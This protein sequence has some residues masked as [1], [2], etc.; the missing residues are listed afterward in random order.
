MPGSNS[1]PNV[2]EGYEI[3]SEL[4]GRPAI[5]LYTYFN[6]HAGT[7]QMGSASVGDR[8]NRRFSIIIAE[9]NRAFW[10]AEKKIAEMG[11]APPNPTWGPFFS[12]IFYY[13]PSHIHL[14]APQQHTA[15]SAGLLCAAYPTPNIHTAR[16]R[17]VTGANV[18]S[19]GNSTSNVTYYNNN[20]CPPVIPPVIFQ[21][22]E[23]CRKAHFG[24]AI[25]SPFFFVNRR[26][27]ISDVVTGSP[28]F[29]L[30]RRMSPKKYFCTKQVRLFFCESPK[31]LEISRLRRQSLTPDKKQNKNIILIIVPVHN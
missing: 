6:R 16:V 1:R 4:P 11:G 28:I 29:F 21:T 2:S 3:T 19:P 26:K 24:G 8:R 25:L 7:L 10:V 17:R 30:I 13:S 22:T 14:E 18:G 5:M 20:C 9:K 15:G 12:P 23:C 31:N 27:A